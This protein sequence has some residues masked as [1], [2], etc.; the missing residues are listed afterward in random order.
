[1]G[2][3]DGATWPKK[4]VV[5]VVAHWLPRVI[6]N[7]SHHHFFQPRTDEFTGIQAEAPLT[8]AQGGVMH[9]TDFKLVKLNQP[10][11]RCYTAG[12]NLSWVS[13]WWTPCSVPVIRSAITFL[14]NSRYRDPQPLELTVMVNSQSDPNSQQQKTKSMLKR[15]SAE[16]E[17][18]SFII[19]TW[20]DVSKGERV[21]AGV[22]LPTQ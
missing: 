3:T 14:V 13:P 19:A 2:W 21:Q 20:R 18:V 4:S 6:I 9:P 8:P 5:V 7:S 16:E 12:A 10:A 1:M 17:H 15:L 22:Q 11:G